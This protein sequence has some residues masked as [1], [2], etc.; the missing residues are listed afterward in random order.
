MGE[1]DQET[2]DGDV[3]RILQTR[4]G[5]SAFRPGQERLIRGVIQ[6]GD[7]LGVL[8]T[9]GGKTL[10]FQLPAMTLAGT[11]VVVSPLISLMKDQVG[12]ALAV[13]LRAR[14]M[15]AMDGQGEQASVLAA[16]EAGDLDML[17]VS[18]ER[19]AT[20]GF[21]RRMAG[22]KIS[23]L[24]V[25]E[26]HCISE[27]GHDF[28]P[29]FREIAKVRP[30]VAGPVLAVTATATPAVRDD[31]VKV[32]A[33]RDPIRVVTSFDRPNI[34]WAVDA[35]P[36]GPQRVRRVV[37]ALRGHQRR[38]AG[39][40]IVYAPTRSQVVS[41]RRVLASVG[42]GAE[43]YHAGMTPEE[44]KSVQ[45]RFLSR[46]ANV[47]VATNAFGMGIDRGDVGLVVH[48]GFPG[49]LES[50]YQEAG[51][52]GRDGQPSR[53]VSLVGRRDWAVPRGFIDR[54]LPSPRTV[55]RVW[56]RLETVRRA[57]GPRLRGRFVGRFEADAPSLRWLSRLGAVRGNDAWTRRL[58]GEGARLD[59][60]E[61]E[62]AVAILTG[63]EPDL[64]ILRAARTDARRRLQAA[65]RYTST[66]GC[67]RKALLGYLGEV[68]QW[69]RCGG[70]DR[71]AG[72]G[73]APAQ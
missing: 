28:R 55:L 11:V 15:T 56:R 14:C 70:C 35:T 69:S 50:Y 73:A 13:G 60:E 31:I 72:S 48:Y 4:F 59:G 17:F 33:L 64:S 19:L 39:A 37:R 6:G 20:E 43:A 1:S 40:A 25:D 54:S 62:G 68:P 9:G 52:A 58:E 36:H 71:C 44:R 38:G 8:P 7:A 41:L 61:E 24:A 5:F 63:R 22:V 32:L 23:L 29:P 18:P 65:R 46:T 12:R 21:R 67:R 47:V 34:H 3:R 53:A 42:L 26:A 30:L 57:Q 66:R 45:E 27:W 49:S 2:G 10:C 51:R 16:F